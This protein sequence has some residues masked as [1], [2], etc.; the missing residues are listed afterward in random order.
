MK[1]WKHVCR[2]EL[3][4]KVHGLAV[5]REL[6]G[7]HVALTVLCML[8]FLRFACVRFTHSRIVRLVPLR[9]FGFDIFFVPLFFFEMLAFALSSVVQ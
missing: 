1:V 5:E 8:K 6:R 2:I 7:G 3:N 4:V 9:R